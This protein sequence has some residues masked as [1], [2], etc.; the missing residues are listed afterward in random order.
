MTSTALIS[1]D[2]G[3]GLVPVGFAEDILKRTAH[4]D[5]PPVLWDGAT[6]LA[7]LAQ[8]WNGHGREKAELKSA[9]MFCEIVLG[10]LLGPN[11]GRGP[12]RGKKDP[13]ADVLP[14]QRVE[15]LRRF[16]GHRELL[17]E[18]VRNGKRSRR[19]L[20]LAV[21]RAEAAER[22]EPEPEDLDIRHGD[23]REVLH[24][25]PQTVALVLTDPPYPAEYLP[26][27][28]EL[29]AFAKIALIDGGSL[30]AYCGQAILPDAL[31]RLRPHLRYWWTI[32]LQH[33]Q[34]QMIPG[35]WISAGW[36]PLV[37]FVAGQRGTQT[38]LADTI[39]GGTPRKTIPTGDD[40][41]WAQSVEAVEPII[42]ALT[43]PG[44][45]IVDPFAGSGTV[46]IAA[47]RFGRR[48]I[49]AELA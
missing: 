29:G 44:D 10:Q 27:W 6:T 47:T 31:D 26:L 4:V 18:E 39:H 38:M 33:G 9:Q 3:P 42:S 24:V 30:I 8:K 12:G 48:F 36:K 19:A 40:G 16:H 21:D 37:W 22:P 1:R 7:A 25:E 34:S 15:E 11:P 2:L 23:F 28:A 13:H 46:G 43:A 35:K 45:L 32:A 5:E 49:G 14:A 20:L 17:V 41:S